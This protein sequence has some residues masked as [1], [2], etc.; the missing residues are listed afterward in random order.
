MVDG[1]IFAMG[2]IGAMGKT[3]TIPLDEST[4]DRLSEHGE[5]RESWDELVNRV[6][7]DVEARQ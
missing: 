7:D 2:V 3:T 4:K 5:H 6:L 1:F